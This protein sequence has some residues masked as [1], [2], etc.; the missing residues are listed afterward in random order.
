MEFPITVKQIAFDKDSTLHETLLFGGKCGDIVAVRPCAE[1]YEKKTFLGILIG[2][3]A[4]SVGCSFNKET[5]ELK[6][7]SRRHNPAIFIP[8]RNSIVYGCGSW[9]G[10][11]ESKDQLRKITDDDIENVWYVKALRQ[12]EENAKT[13]N[14]E[15]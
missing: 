2:E 9:W 5:G 11:I 1:E 12:L 3:I 4:L 6:I 14:Q 15:S 10:K 13:E 7:G 8:D